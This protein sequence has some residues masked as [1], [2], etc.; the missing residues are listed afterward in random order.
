M[1]T[2]YIDIT[3]TQTSWLNTGIQRTVRN[4][5]RHLPELAPRCGFAATPVVFREQPS[6][7]LTPRHRRLHRSQ[8]PC[9]SRWPAASSCGY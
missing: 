7:F 1:T 8:R 3:D 4:I 2:I 6:T 5:A 9:G